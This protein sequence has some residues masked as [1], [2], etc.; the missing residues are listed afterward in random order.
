MQD[1]L[2]RQYHSETALDPSIPS[3]SNDLTHEYTRHA[4]LYQAKSEPTISYTARK[5]H[6]LLVEDTESPHFNT[7]FLAAETLENIVA[8]G[9]KGCLIFNRVVDGKCSQETGYGTGQ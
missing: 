3:A 1:N 4:E 9:E 8:E 7:L 5:S 2:F 6:P